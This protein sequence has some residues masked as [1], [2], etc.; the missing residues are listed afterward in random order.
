MAYDLLSKSFREG[1]KLL[2]CGNGGSASDSE[3][4][5]GELMKGFKSKR[6]LS[7]EVRQQFV[8]CFGEDGN[9]LADNL[10]G[11]LPAISL[12][13]HHSLATAYANDVNPDMVFAQQVYGYGKAGDILIGLSTSGNSDNVVH[14]VK[15]AQ[16]LGMKTIGLTGRSGG[17]MKDLCEVTLSVPEDETADVQERHLPIYH[18]LCTMLE[19]AFFS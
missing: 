19:I 1:G 8:D 5:V 2:V 4:I 15:T 9:F 3:H 18:A 10:Q 14:A 16:V 17:K 6:I 7:K 12:T 11:A 13:S